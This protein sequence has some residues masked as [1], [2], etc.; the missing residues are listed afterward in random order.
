[1]RTIR[2]MASVAVVG[3]LAL[4]ATSC[5]E[6]ER[7][8]EG[9]D[10]RRGHVHLRRRR[11]T[12]DVRPAV[13]HGRRDLPGHPPDV[14]GPARHRA[15]QR[16]G[17]PRAGHRV[18][19]QRGRH[20]V[21]V[22]AARR[23]DLPR[24]RALQRRGGLRQ[25]RADVRPEQGRPGRRRVLGLRHGRL[26][27][28]P[29]ELALPGLRGHRRVRGGRHHQPLHVGLPD[30]ADPVLAGDAVADGDGGGQRQRHRHRGRGLRL[31]G[32]RRRPG[33]HR[34]LQV[35]R[36]RRGQRLD[37]AR[38]QRR[39]LGR[40]SQVQR[41]GLPRDPRR[42]H[43]SPGARGR[44]HRRLRPPE[45]DRLGR[46]RGGGQLRRDPRPVQ[47]LLLRAQPRPATPT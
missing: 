1:M 7:S 37:H 21:D 8:S 20:R 34:P 41:A 39:L 40:R 38:G 15:R 3:T 12:R 47:H 29:E 44:Q 46:P 36:V 9:G 30:D 14:P 23:R 4:A 25:L 10:S 26:L 6:S 28:R 32:V 11:R 13:R 24:R 5:A 27:Q 19:L 22:H 42:E 16:R 43:P 18:D 17:R 31:P 35:R 45:P 33:R 2:K